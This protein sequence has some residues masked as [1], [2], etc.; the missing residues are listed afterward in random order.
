MAVEQELPADALYFTVVDVPPP[1]WDGRQIGVADMLTLASRKLPTQLEGSVFSEIV[2][3]FE[4][5]LD[6]PWAVQVIVYEAGRDDGETG[7]DPDDPN[8]FPRRAQFDTCLVVQESV[9]PPPDLI[10]DGFAVKVTEHCPGGRSFDLSTTIVFS[11]FTVGA[12]FVLQLKR[13]LLL[14]L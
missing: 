5:V 2:T 10:L 11:H 13:K 7:Y 12:L 4:H 1:G 8:D 3:V 14:P 9:L 6:D